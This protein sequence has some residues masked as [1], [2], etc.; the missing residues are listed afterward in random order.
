MALAALGTFAVPA[1]AAGSSFDTANELRELCVAI[2]DDELSAAKRISCISFLTGAVKAFQISAARNGS[3]DFCL[4]ASVNAQ[5]IVENFLD[6]LRK[7]PVME[8]GNS[9]LAILGSLSDKFPC[10]DD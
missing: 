4:N 6:Y 3:K 8:S 2:D 5:V 10:A 9:V 7:Y 1:S